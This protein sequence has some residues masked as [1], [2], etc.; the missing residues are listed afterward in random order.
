MFR[1]VEE[2]E[3]GRGLEGKE[4]E[5]AFHV[6]GKGGKPLGEEDPS[7][8]LYDDPFA[9]Q[10]PVLDEQGNI[11][12]E[13][14]DLLQEAVVEQYEKSRVE[15]YEE[16]HDDAKAVEA[17][18]REATEACLGEGI[19]KDIVTQEQALNYINGYMSEEEMGRL[20][21]EQLKVI[22]AWSM[23]NMA[24]ET[25]KD[26][27][28]MRGE[29]GEFTNE[30]L[31][32]LEGQMERLITFE[33]RTWERLE[34]YGWEFIYGVCETI[35]TAGDYVA[36]GVVWL[37]GQIGAPLLLATMGE[38][39]Y[40]KHLAYWDRKAERILGDNWSR[41]QSE[42]NAKNHAA[43]A[44]ERKVGGMASALGAMGPISLL[45]TLNP[46]AGAALSGL[47]TAGKTSR[48]ALET[49]NGIGAALGYGLVAGTIDF[50]LNAVASTAFQA[51]GKKGWGNEFVRRVAKTKG[52]DVAL[53]TIAGTLVDTGADTFSL[54]AQH[55]LRK[56]YNPNYKGE[57][58][59]EEVFKT[60]AVSLVMNGGM[61]L[62]S[63]LGGVYETNLQK[64]SRDAEYFPVD[65]E[66]L[67]RFAGYLARRVIWIDRNKGNISFLFVFHNFFDHGILSIDYDDGQIAALH[68]ALKMHQRQITLFNLR[69][70][71]IALYAHIPEFLCVFY[72]ECRL[73]SHVLF[74]NAAIKASAHTSNHRNL[75]N[76]RGIDERSFS[77][78]ISHRDA[79][80]IGDYF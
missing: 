31:K 1:T 68:I 41:R 53:R 65:D 45:S 8:E 34:Y 26:Y 50:T 36:A 75:H 66:A 39:E 58:G 17:A 20:S 59:K 60:I 46:V 40:E 37:G 73:S 19:A 23:L 44:F 78:K 4:E 72:A 51:R 62:G 54:I 42:Q 49:G 25:A 6:E 5:A 56:M 76:G 15:N 70:H 80:C 30:Y 11:I 22:E 77:Q 61:R 12:L 63:N 24:Y 13:N 21:K 9:L 69:E 71:G 28:F 74:L 57:L 64:G 55:N 67:K 3:Q 29:Y 18:G 38:E 79:Q 32:E 7:Y 47:N 33:D 35:E 43:S 52:G 27:I 14:Q 2:E 16:S 10:E 48:E